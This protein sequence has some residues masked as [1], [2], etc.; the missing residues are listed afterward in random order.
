MQ[1]CVTRSSIR[2]L[3]AVMPSTNTRGTS[4]VYQGSVEI[5]GMICLKE[6]DGGGGYYYCT[7]NGISHTIY[8]IDIKS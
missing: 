4:V 3:M 8:E 6:R 7:T 2:S 5:C 1:R